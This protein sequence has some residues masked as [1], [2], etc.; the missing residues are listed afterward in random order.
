MMKQL[1]WLFMLLLGIIQP[2]EAS[3]PYTSNSVLSTG[4]WMK[5]EIPKTGIYKLTYT[6]LKKMGFTDPT[7]VSVHGYGGWPLEE[8]FTQPYTDDLPTVAVWKGTDYILFYGKGPIK[9]EYNRAQRK[10][11][12]TNNP[13]STCGYY[14]LTDA[15]E[16]KEMEII[17]SLE[18]ASLQIK[19]FDDYALFEEEAVSVNKSG[20]DLFGPS[21]IEKAKDI[22]FGPFPGITHEEGLAEFRFIS[23]VKTSKN[24]S[25]HI[26][27]QQVAN[28]TVAP[29]DD[30]FSEYIMANAVSASG[31]WTSEKTTY[32]RVTLKYEESNNQAAH[33]DYVRLHF[34]RKLQTYD[35][36][37]TLFRSQLSIGKVSR[38]VIQ[39]ANNQTL[40]FDVTDGLNPKRMETKLK[41]SELSFTIPEG[42]LR[43]FAL[44][45]F[46]KPFTTLAAQAVS[47]Q[48]LH[49]VSQSDMV[50]I[51][52]PAFKS[53]ALRLAEAHT[54]KDGLN[55]IQVVT[56]E[57]IYNEFS[58]GTPD[59]TAYRRFMKMLFDRNPSAPNAPK[60]LLLFGDGSYDNRF[61]SEAW[62]R[63]KYLMNN[64]LLTYQTEESLNYYSY[65]ADDYFGWLQD[66]RTLH[67]G[68]GRFPIRTIEQAQQT[69]DKVISY[70]NKAQ[71]GAWKNNVCFVADDGN[72][73]D[74]FDTRHLSDANL[75]AE[76]IED[77]CPQYITQKT[78]FDSY[79]KDYSGTT[80]YPAVK[81]EIQKK[82]RDG[83]FLI[84]Y[85]GHGNTS[86]WSDEKVLTQNDIIQANYIHL[87]IWITATCDFC[88]FDDISTSAGEDVF[89]NKI[90]G[91]IAL[92]TTSRVAFTDINFEINNELIKQLFRK[93]TNH[94]LTLGDVLK[95]TKKITANERKLG[96]CLI[97]D[98]ALRLAYPEYQIKLT[99]INNQPIPEDIIQF[100][101]LQKITLE[102]EVC[103][104]E[105]NSASEFNGIIHFTLF[106]G[107]KTVTTLGNNKIKINNK[108]TSLTVKYNDYTNILFKGNS[109]VSK[110][111][112]NVSFT[113]PK[114]IAY[115]TT[116]VGKMS[117]YALDETL[118]KEAQGYFNRYKVGET[119]HNAAKD[120]DAPEIRALYLND[121]T[122][123]SGGKVN[124]TPYF[125]A[126]LWDQ[127]GINITGNSVGHDIT[128]CIDNKLYCNYTL[129]SYFENRVGSE[130]EGLIKFSIPKLEPGMHTAEFKVW[131]IM[132][133]SRNETF[134]FEVVEGLK[135]FLSELSV[136]GIPSKDQVQFKL[137]HNR[138]ES[139]MKVSLMVYDLTGRLQWRH[140]ETGSSELFKEYMITWDLRNGAGSRLRPGIYLY[141]AGI[142]TD[143]SQE[144]T[145]TKKLLILAP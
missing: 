128:L 85:T 53:E 79:K 20:R 15:T 119:F 123:T 34:K 55:N 58:S 46:D 114:D 24:V 29:V 97:G 135:P 65:A 115:D 23:K 64:M 78:F 59:A 71:A 112:F 36:P 77:N 13:Y 4:K 60:Y 33:L 14:F 39:E 143:N 86:S 130:G 105:E 102:G 56:P 141:R 118:G 67:I 127:S 104:P 106:D 57:E 32:P 139:R 68:I 83:L 35:E 38:L 10:F 76:T 5:I 89:L 92:F 73:E 122:F 47:C 27:G 1:F 62:K 138:P 125:V 28:S 25:L 116:N 75:I 108:D 113:I 9:W 31:N 40:V 22:P 84:N 124:T 66:N 42:Q 145:E 3:N 17:P 144:T 18:E 61:I 45:R 109:L 107:R 12:H 117:F 136:Y 54:E 142:S 96:F 44:V 110:G 99:T 74:K 126:R 95:E 90:S 91:G 49:S 131:D 133:N 16:T 103:T 7:K 88:R 48:D 98:P 43:E 80:T 94:T 87:P 50:I 101:A 134:S 120:T 137:S 11:V 100:N 82:L 111:K 140:D 129:N 69:V 72:N 41:G 21:F 19:S 8:D 37:Y 30:R 63:N 52:P 132:N 51:T 26:D 93:N 2:S 81:A 121:S 70:M 6:E